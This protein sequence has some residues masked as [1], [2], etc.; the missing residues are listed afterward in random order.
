[1]YSITYKLSKDNKLPRLAILCGVHGNESHSVSQVLKLLQSVKMHCGNKIIDLDKE[2][3][4]NKNTERTPDF[5]RKLILTYSEITFCMG[6]NELG[7]SAESREF[8]NPSYDD[9]TI[10]NRDFNREFSLE[11]KMDDILDI[12]KKILEVVDNNDVIIDVHN[13]PLCMNTL[14]FGLDSK[15]N[16]FV[17]IA[18]ENEIDFISTGKFTDGILKNYINNTKFST[19]KVGLTAELNGMGYVNNEVRKASKEFLDNLILK[20]YKFLN[21]NTFS[22]PSN[23]NIAIDIVS[24]ARGIISYNKDNPLAFYKAG[25]VI[26]YIT[27]LEGIPNGTVT[28]PMSGKL[29]ALQSSLFVDAGRSFGTFVA[30]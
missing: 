30:V 19:K 13:S 9:E 1:M 26:A 2:R 12:K 8:I 14:V 3:E 29:V 24:P 20:A 11:E 17:D 16:S 27:N 25:E 28:A 21:V 10:S 6:V 7:L 5:I 23:A 22:T 15:I 4:Y 18:R